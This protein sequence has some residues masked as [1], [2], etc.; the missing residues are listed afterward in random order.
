MKKY[1]T[2]ENILLVLAAVVL[3][4]FALMD[5]VPA[6]AIAYGAALLVL[7][8]VLSFVATKAKEII[9]G[10]RKQLDDVR[11]NRDDYMRK[12]KEYWN[13]YDAKSTECNMLQQEIQRLRDQVQISEMNE[14]VAAAKP[15]VKKTRVKK[16]AAAIKAELQ[17]VTANLKKKKN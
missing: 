8:V 7:A 1:F 10:L 15:A 3:F 11:Q 16:S 6:M 5:P 13:K 9:A 4:V 14:P 17:D 2:I 12:Y